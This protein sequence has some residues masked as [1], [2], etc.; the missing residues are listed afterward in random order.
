M[1]FLGLSTAEICQL[2]AAS[3]P[4]EDQPSVLYDQYVM[5]LNGIASHASKAN[6]LTVVA[7]QLLYKCQ[8]VNTSSLVDCLQSFLHYLKSFN[9]PV[10]LMAHNNKVFD[11]RILVKAFMKLNLVE[12]LQLLIQG[13]VDTLPLFREIIPHR[14]SYKQ[15]QLVRDILDVS[16]DAHNGL[17]DVKALRDLLT[18]LKPTDQ[19]YDRNSF[20]FGHVSDSLEHH[21][22]VA[23]NL[24]SLMPLVDRKVISKSMAQKMAGSNLNYHHLKLAFQRGGMEGIKCLLAEKNSNTLKARVTISKKI[25]T[26]LINFM[27]TY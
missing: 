14:P 12:E 16:Y 2:S 22:R 18:H 27:E 8:P 25:V 26:K 10:V 3:L 4:Q 6:S 9:K 13:F 23:Y 20:S 24:P 1:F 19:Q 21:T 15:E 7:G 11:S 5:P 17:E